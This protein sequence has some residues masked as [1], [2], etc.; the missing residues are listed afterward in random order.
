MGNT[1]VGSQIMVQCIQTDRDSLHPH[2]FLHITHYYLPVRGQTISYL[3]QIYRWLPP[4]SH[5]RS[6]PV[7]LKYVVKPAKNR[8]EKSHSTR[9]HNQNHAAMYTTE[10]KR[11]SYPYTG[12]DR[13]L[14]LREVE[15]SI[16]SRQLTYEGGK[17]ASHT[18]WP[19]LLPR[20]YP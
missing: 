19:S 15:A 3:R 11:Y 12:L 4:P 10:Q 20:R 1:T 7:Y 16:T 14:G 9:R 5:S 8:P 2:H 6:R 18:H 17:V 13:P